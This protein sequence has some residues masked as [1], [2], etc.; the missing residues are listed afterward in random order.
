MEFPPCTAAFFD[1]SSTLAF[2]RASADATRIEELAVYPGVR[3]VLADLSG[4]GVRLGIITDP[5]PVPA[6][7]FRSK[8]E[9]SGVLADFDA[10]L[11]FLSRYGSPRSF[12]EAVAAVRG[13][14][15]CQDAMLYYI[16]DDP[17]ERTHAALAGFLL[18]P[19]P[20]LAV[21]VL[22]RQ[23][24]L[25]FLRVRVPPAAA[26]APWRDELRKHAVVPL[27]MTNEPGNPTAVTVYAIADVTTAAALD[28]LGF[29]VDRLGEADE[30]Q[31][32][33]LYLL[34]DDLQTASGFLV[35]KGNASA[36]F[37]T[38]PEASQVVGST[39][40]GL[41]IS[42]PAGESVEALHF[43]ET[44]HGHTRK[45]TP[46]VV[47]LSDHPASPPQV[48]RFTDLLAADP[49]SKEEVDMLKKE[50]TDE[51]VKRM[52]QRYTGREP[53]SS[54]FG[55]RS[56]HVH[57]PGNSQAV[58]TLVSDLCSELCP[59]ALELVTVS[60]HCF[61]HEARL[62][63]NVIATLAA[64]SPDVDGVVVLSAHLDST[65]R[66][67]ENPYCGATHPAPGADDD[68]SGIAGVLL[69][70][71]VCA[72]LVPQRSRRREIRFVLWNG[73]EDGLV[74][75]RVYATAQAALGANLVAVL[76]MD[77]IAFNR[78]S[79][80]QFE[81]HAG[82]E[83]P[84]GPNAGQT[85]SGSADLAN[86]IEALRETI[87]PGLPPAQ[88]SEGADDKARGM[89]DHTSFHYAGY[90]ACLISEDFFADT[91]GEGD[92]NPNYHQPTDTIDTINPQYAAE[93][94]RMVAAAAW[95]AATRFPGEG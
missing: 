94:A 38:E 65:A 6:A 55:I 34:R 61:I 66:A 22:Q 53:G 35:E 21:T 70:A 63:T 1:I 36:F 67:Q 60:R 27:H 62:L 54:E 33:E 29:W 10:S 93:I 31:T 23:A 71:R 25:R 47:T 26:A 87:S 18:A 75:S 68:A 41:L 48:P 24:P 72:K 84:F 12:A 14:S 85:A 28:D 81:L 11:I 82:I 78:G 92:R 83:N 57:H 4:A 80:P 95:V 2:V 77:M 59:I 50:I 42:I 49:L 46:S 73:E 43:H 19:H 91:S 13:P 8:L 86:L 76:Q 39:H 37:A 45:L 15:G 79:P 20:A 32:S 64:S 3:K 30:P 9:E 16:G 7:A 52:V 17:S 5:A 56:R 88:I 58:E 51:L 44:R 69:A 40:E 74:G 89:S 90:P